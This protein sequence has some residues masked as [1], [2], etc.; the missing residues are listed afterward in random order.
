[1][2]FQL[3]FLIEYNDFSKLFVCHRMLEWT[4]TIFKRHITLHIDDNKLQTDIKKNKLFK[5]IAIRINCNKNPSK[6][7]DHILCDKVEILYGFTRCTLILNGMRLQ[8]ILFQTKTKLS[9]IWNK[10]FISMFQTQLNIY[11]NSIGASFLLTQRTC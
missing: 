3:Y 9:Y 1:M 10:P 8:F 11:W 4:S 7:F 6:S 5:L 2:E